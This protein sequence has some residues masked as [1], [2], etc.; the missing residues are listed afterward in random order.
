MKYC[1]CKIT[2]F[3]INSKTSLE[4]C[5]LWHNSYIWTDRLNKQKQPFGDVLQIGI[6]KNFAIITGKH[7]CWNL[8]LIKLQSWRL[9]LYQK[10]TPIQVFLWEYCKIVKNS[11]LYKTHPVAAS[12]QNENKLKEHMI[13]FITWLTI[14]CY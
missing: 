10:E 2:F 9:Q 5:F 8:F 12:E 1:F 6:L 14:P 4:A 11:F 3:F 13:Y 7:L